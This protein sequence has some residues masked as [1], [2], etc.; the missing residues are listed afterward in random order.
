[1][2]VS[3]QVLSLFIIALPIASIAW[4]IAH[5]EVVRELRDIC[6]RKS[7]TCKRIYE[8]TF[9]YLFTCEYCFSRYVTAAFLISHLQASFSGL[10]RISHRRLYLGLGG[11]RLHEPL[12]QDS[13]RSEERA[14]RNQH[15]RGSIGT[16]QVASRF[17]T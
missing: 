14:R 8:C 7:K 9:F 12:R 13:T 10:A 15:R 1:M 4:T 2:T 17:V 3:L 16:A 5:E 11:E 6:L